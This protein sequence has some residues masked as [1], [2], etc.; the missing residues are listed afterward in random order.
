MLLELVL[1]AAVLWY[2]F[3]PRVRY[4]DNIPER[5]TPFRSS[6]ACNSIP[7][8]Y[9]TQ[10]IYMN[11]PNVYPVNW[12]YVKSWIW[13]KGKEFEYLQKQRSDV[14]KSYGK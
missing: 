13:N 9:N 1:A 14:I 11:N 2:V 4:P 10:R 12:N 7:D 3:K 5:F 6:S 8:A